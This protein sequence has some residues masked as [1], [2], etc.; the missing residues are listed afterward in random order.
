MI[1]ILR[2]TNGK[3]GCCYGHMLHIINSWHKRSFITFF[4]LLLLAIFFSSSFRNC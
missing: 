2:G 3:G 1:I 4:S